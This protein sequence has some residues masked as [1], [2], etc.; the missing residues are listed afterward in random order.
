MLGL[1]CRTLIITICYFARF[2]FSCLFKHFILREGMLGSFDLLIDGDFSEVFRRD[3]HGIFYV[4][5][6]PVTLYFFQISA[7]KTMQ[8]DKLDE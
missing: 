1:A 6:F 3:Q 5:E 2:K 4:A 7:L 8:D